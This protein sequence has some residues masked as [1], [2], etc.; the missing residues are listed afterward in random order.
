MTLKDSIL[1]RIEQNE[2]NVW[3]PIDFVD[4][5]TRDAV[6]KTLQRLVKTNELRRIGRGLYD[7][8]RINALTKI[9]DAPDY[10]SIIDAVARRDQTHVLLDGMTCAND[11]GLT[12]AV[13]GQV[14][15]YTDGRQRP[16]KINNLT[17]KFKLT[18]SS[19]LY[20]AGRPGMRIIQ[21]LYWF[22][23]ELQT[24]NSFN[25][26]VIRKLK[27]LLSSSVKKDEICT[28]ITTGMHTLPTW[29]QKW[30]KDFFLLV[31]D[32]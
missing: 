18:A 8:T 4:L 13:P 30:L 3:T 11:L 19:K 7:K 9:A 12:N 6:D 2:A 22:K 25:Q 21:S 16:I 28:D 5:G 1:Q 20:W 29:M 32:I 17:I 26:E 24:D 15:V 27:E 23:N 31:E 14:I 10:H